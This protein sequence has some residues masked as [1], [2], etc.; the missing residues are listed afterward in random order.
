MRNHEHLTGYGLE[1]GTLVS[2]RFINMQT[3]GDNQQ[4]HSSNSNSS[5][6]KAHH[7]KQDKKKL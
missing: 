1:D 7:I 2:V 5:S 6:N 4:E 3:G